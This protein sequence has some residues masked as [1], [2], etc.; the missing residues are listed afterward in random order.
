MSSDRRAGSSRRSSRRSSRS[1][2]ATRTKTAV[3]K[4]KL[5]VPLVSV[6]LIL[7]AFGLSVLFLLYPRSSSFEVFPP[8]SGR[9]AS[10]IFDHH[11]HTRFSDGALTP[12]ELVS[13]AQSAGCDA[14]VVSDHSNFSPDA[15]P[16]QLGV[17]KNLRETHPEMLIFGGLELNMPSYAGREHAGLIADPSVDAETL[18]QL[19]SLA[20]RKTPGSSSS[21]VR[22]VA[23]SRLLD[24]ITDYRSFRNGLLLI[25]NHPS[26]EG[27]DIEE[28][29]GDIIRWNTEAPVVT[30]IEGAT[31][32]HSAHAEGSDKKV[33]LNEDYWD[34][35]VAEVGGVW[36][37]LWSSGHQVWGALASSDYHGDD[38]GSAPCAFARTHLIVP[39]Q[40]YRGVISALRKGTFWADHGFILDQ[41]SF[42]ATLD[43]LDGPAFP[44]SVVRVGNKRSVANVALLLQRGTGSVGQPLTVEIIADCSSGDWVILNEQELAPADSSITLP[45]SLASTGEDG[46]SCSIRARVRL[47]HK[48][49]ADYVAYTNPIRFILN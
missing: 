37:R 49:S 17:L 3:L 33:P 46:I 47:K 36:D 44:G 30:A 14:L 27:E 25:Y 7:F 11:T 22:A 10:L 13:V 43:G 42:S 24:A 5:N 48:E 45:V 28:N 18:L 12:G 6:G 41:L 21:A 8:W 23:D 1:K 16:E 9:N 26:R 34:P 29:L 35:V 15:I 4:G 38:F 31:G 32:H 40:S 39:E 19:Q 20:E 2:R